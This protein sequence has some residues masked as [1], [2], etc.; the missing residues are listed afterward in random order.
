MH[1]GFILLIIM[2]FY[3][4]CGCHYVG[5]SHYATSHLFWKLLS[6]SKELQV[7]LLPAAAEPQRSL[8]LRRALLSKLRQ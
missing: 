6:E 3:P 4:P 5:Q 7:V 1:L 8:T 2:N